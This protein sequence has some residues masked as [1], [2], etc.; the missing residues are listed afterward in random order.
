MIN[1]KGITAFVFVL[2][3]TTLSAQTTYDKDYAFKDRARKAP[4]SVFNKFLSAGM[5]PSDH[6]LT[7]AEQ[8]KV[9]KAFSILPPLYKKI[10][11]KHL[12][13]I[14]F[15]DN[16]PNTALTSPLETADTLQQFNITFRA[17]ILNETISQW[18]TWKEKSAFDATANPELEIQVDAGTLDAIDYILLH[19]ATHIVDAVLNLTPHAEVNDAVVSPS[20]FTEG[21][22]LKMNVPEAKYDGA[23]LA[24]TRFRSGKPQPISLAEE[25][26]N[27]LGE[28][29]FASLYGMASWHEDLAELVAI[30]HLTNKLK[31]PFVIYLK[32]QGRVK[33]AFEPMKRKGVKKRVKQLRFFYG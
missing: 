8:E 22:W 28:T 31:Q 27:A 33:A 16:M 23:L 15:M 13:S 9:N 32:E 25:T 11:K 4:E 21:T 1:K 20:K 14:S 3:V 19:E 7:A 5:N 30:Y 18:A 2:L 17:G 10:L 6:A 24:Q 26:Y 29:P 12:H